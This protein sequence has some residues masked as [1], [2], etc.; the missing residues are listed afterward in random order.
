MPDS[1]F[2]ITE[3]DDAGNV[4]A[5]YVQSSSDDV[6]GNTSRVDVIVSASTRPI[7]VNE[8]WRECC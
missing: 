4:I 2:R 3:N 5:T 6:S 1:K 8:T 7:V